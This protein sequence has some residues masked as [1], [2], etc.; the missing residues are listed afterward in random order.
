MADRNDLMRADMEVGTRAKDRGDPELAKLELARYDRLKNKRASVFDSAWETL[1]RYCLPNMSDIDETK[2][3]GTSGWSDRVF[4]STAIEDART[5]TTGQSNWATPAAEPWFQW[6]PPKYLNMEEDDD[7]AIWCGICTEIALDELSRSNYYRMS[8]MQYKSRTVF[9]TGQMHIEEG[10]NM[11]VNCS[12]RKI[13]T[14]CIDKDDEDQVDTVYT[15]FKLS[16]RAAAQK[17]GVD[18]LGEKVRKAVESNDGKQMDQEFVFLHVIRPRAELERIQGKIDGPNKPIAS[19]YVSF[20]DKICVKVGGYDEMPDSVTRFDD[21]GTGTVWG[22]SPAFETLT[23]IR[24]IN[25]MVRFIDGQVELRA[26]PRILEPVGL[27]GQVDLRPG[28]ITTFDPNNGGEAG[29]PREWMTQADVAGT[30]HSVELKQQ[31]I[32]RM[33]YVDVFRALSQVDVNRATAFGIA[34]VMGEKLEQLSPM[35]M[36]II[37]EKTGVDLKRIF[38]ILFRNGRFPKP[39]RSMYV[40][41]ATGKKLRLAMP[42]VTYTSRLALALKA[43][44]NKA[45]METLQFVTQCA[46][47]MNRPEL[48]DNW[49]LDA[50]FRGYAINQGMSARYE[51]PMRQVIALRAARAKQQAQQRAMDMAEQAATAAGKLG[52]APQ[53]LQD[54][55]SDQI[56]EGTPGNVIPM[57]QAG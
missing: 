24:Q 27:K 56:P 19:I 11:L 2:T 6:G 7:G 22:Y 29:L 45:T 28:G 52:K 23:N 17:F 51:R 43:L 5:C 12:S 36:R 53:K 21:W 55:V 14:Y 57:Q 4:D 38:G 40:P 18:N 39:P 35:F 1:S 48:L 20:D 32:H 30:E 34:Q 47:D 3:E 16:A 42:E 44:Q 54:A 31:A 9:G 37:T 46:K 8:G 13:G 50:A 15:E 41:D 10:R 25:Y 49:D 26:N 33:F